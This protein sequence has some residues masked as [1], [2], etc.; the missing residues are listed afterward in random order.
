MT[1]FLESFL[2][3]NWRTTLTGILTAITG[4]LTGLAALPYELGDVATIIHPDAKPW[5]LKVS[6]VATIVLYILKSA[7]TKDGA[8]AGNGSM[9]DPMRVSTPTGK[10]RVIGC[11]LAAFLFTGCESMRF[12]GS[13]TY[14]GQHGD[15]SLS[16]DGKSIIGDIRLKDTR[17]LS[18]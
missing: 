15:Y 1:K 17:G 3:A 2:G 14:S 16:S 6:G 12:R 13:V 8:V 7:M 10:E 9:F 11:L 18:K 5:L 4:A